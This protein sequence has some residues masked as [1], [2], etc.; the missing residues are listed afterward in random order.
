LSRATSR[1]PAWI[2]VV[3]VMAAVYNLLWGGLV[4]LAPNLFFTL[5]GLE[6]PAYP[7]IW[8]CVGM[9]V[10][11]YGV[12]DAIAARDPARHWPIV[13]VGLLGKVFGPIGFVYASLITRQL[14]VEFGLVIIPNDLIWWIPFAAILY[15]AARVNQAHP[16]AI[17]EPSLTPEAAMERAHDQ[18]GLSIAE[19]SASEP[20]MIVFLRHLGCTFCRETL[21]DLE[22]QQHAI[23]KQG[24]ELVIVHMSE[25]DDARPTLL[26]YGL[27]QVPRISDPRQCLYR[28]FDL[29]RGSAGELFGP[30]VWW[31]GLV[32]TLKGNTVG[33]LK[34]DGFQMPG[35]FIVD[36]GRIVHATRHK[37]AAE[38]PEYARIVCE[39]LAPTHAELA[40]RR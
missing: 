36:H 27:E 18:Y 40:A 38:R 20:V 26:R 39:S 5:G 11:V 9:I 17:Y 7:A 8:Q 31:R 13:L 33:M 1:T 35:V 16:D 3:L 12:G 6:P 21:R 34:G 22:R 10:G 15:H 2:P 24:C 32:A 14:P 37:S 28:A 19:R 29:R 30:R 23:T 4:V 25:E